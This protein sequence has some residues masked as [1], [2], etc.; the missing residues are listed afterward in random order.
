MAMLEI[1]FDLPE[2][3]IRGL[4]DGTLKRKGGVIYNSDGGVVMWLKET[5]TAMQSQA[6][7]T[8]LPPELAS[9]LQSLQGLMGL[10]IGLQA[11]TLGVTVAGFVILA[12]KMDAIGRKL[13]QIAAAIDDLTDEVQWQRTVRDVERSADLLGALEHA[14]WAE[15]N[16]ELGELKGLRKEFSQSHVKYAMLMRSM[17]AERRAHLHP[18]VYLSFYRHSAMAGMAKIRCDWLLTGAETALASH[19]ELASMLSS[20]K[21]E[22]L[23]PMRT[24]DASRL[25]NISPAAM[26]PLKEMARS[27]AEEGHR[28]VSHRSEI[29]WCRDKG[30]PLA[31]WELLGRDVQDRAV[32]FIRPTA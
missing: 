19:H 3:I 9:Q 15:L 24:F 27:L 1:L 21:E 30:L 8:P 13:D 31:E 7:S 28:V 29:E 4:A 12:K 20:A 2:E 14:Q 6:A 11:L 16:G 10:Q 17:D 22:F 5:G 18:D 32:V 23:A 25:I 26:A